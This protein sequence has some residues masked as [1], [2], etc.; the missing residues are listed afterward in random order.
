MDAT[1]VTLGQEFSGYAAAVRKG[2]ERLSRILVEVEELAL[3]GTAVG[4]GINCPEGLAEAAIA[5]MAERSGIPFTEAVDHFEAQAGKDATVNASGTL[6]TV[7]V[8]LFKIAPPASSILLGLSSNPGG[9]VL[10]R[11]QQVSY[12]T[13]QLAVP[14]YLGAGG[15]RIRISGDLLGTR[16]FGLE[17]FLQVL[18]HRFAVITKEGGGEVRRVE[19]GFSRLSAG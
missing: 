14:V 13:S 11:S 8:S 4:T 18:I 7:A 16:Q 15:R 5:V 17:E 2:V 9:R 3:G 12:L 10:D 19:L 1:P 6:K